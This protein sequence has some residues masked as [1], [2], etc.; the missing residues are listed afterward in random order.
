MSKSE[1]TN[2]LESYL[3]NAMRTVRPP[4]DV[5]QRLRNRI[6]SLEP[7]VI[8]KRISNWELTIITIGSVMSAAMVIL[9]IARAFY[10]FFNRSKRSA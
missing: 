8:A 4:D 10:Y 2:Q 1:D 6:G 3:D 7:T 9:T 5:M